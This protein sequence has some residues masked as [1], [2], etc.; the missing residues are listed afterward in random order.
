VQL[1]NRLAALHEIVS[2]CTRAMYGRDADVKVPRNFRLLEELE[3]GE[4]GLGDVCVSYGLVDDD[5]T[6]SNWT[7]TILGPLNTVFE[8]RIYNLRIYCGPDYPTKPPVVFFR[9]RIN[10]SC[11]NGATGQVDPTRCGI[12]HNWTPDC[13]LETLLV[14]LR[15]EMTSATNRRLNQPPEGSEFPPPRDIERFG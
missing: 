6:L 7:G 2:G 4:H 13:T 10:I 5:M 3:K 11:V 9:T 8:N 12:L 15:R 1:C 14:E